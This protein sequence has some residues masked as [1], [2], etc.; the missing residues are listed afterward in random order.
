MGFS[1]LKGLKKGCSR[2]KDLARGRNFWGFKNLKYCAVKKGSQYFP[3]ERSS[4]RFF[5]GPHLWGYM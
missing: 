2:K 5:P 1:I 3:K 4:Q